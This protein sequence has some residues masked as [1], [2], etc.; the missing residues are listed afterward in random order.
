VRDSCPF[1]LVDDD[2]EGISLDDKA[3]DVPPWTLAHHTEG[4][5]IIDESSFTPARDD[6]PTVRNL[7]RM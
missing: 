3:K 7:Y 2:C 5:R 4:L 6:H 1:L